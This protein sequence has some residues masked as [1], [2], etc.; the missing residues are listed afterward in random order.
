MVISFPQFLETVRARRG[1]TWEALAVARKLEPH[2]LTELVGGGGAV[3]V[4][5]A[6]GLCQALDLTA[7]ETFRGLTGLPLATVPRTTDALRHADVVQFDRLYQQHRAAAVALLQRLLLPPL[8]Y[9]RGAALDPAM[10]TEIALREE[11]V[12]RLDLAY[13]LTLQLPALRQMALAE[14]VM[15]GE[16]VIAYAQRVALPGAPTAKIR[17]LREALLRLSSA[18][19]GM[20]KLSTVLELDSELPQKGVFLQMAWQLWE[21]P[22]P[23]VRLFVL[24]CRWHTPTAIWLR[25]LREQLVQ[26]DEPCANTDLAMRLTGPP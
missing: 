17:R 3:H 1:E 19:I 7:A 21:R 26:G 23:H 18:P 9:G 20:Q 22:P 16:D 5:E 6:V 25:Q 10:V 15:L 14:G 11:S 2:A 8:H 4:R 13:P 24:A 12:V